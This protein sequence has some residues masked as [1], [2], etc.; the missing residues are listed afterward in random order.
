MLCY[1]ISHVFLIGVMFKI[2]L[3]VTVFICCV[4][5]VLEMF[6]NMKPHFLWF[7]SLGTFACEAIIESK[8]HVSLTVGPV[9]V[10]CNL[11]NGPHSWAFVPTL[12]SLFGPSQIYFF[13]SSQSSSLI[14]NVSLIIKN[15]IILTH[16]SCHLTSS[17]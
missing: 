16:Y 10:L 12:Q 2:E 8:F 5:G 3:Q 7:W 14:A 9:I 15:Y 1:L 4:F 17:I 6:W 13:F 11:T